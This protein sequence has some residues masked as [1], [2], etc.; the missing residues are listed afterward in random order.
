MY[1]GLRTSDILHKKTCRMEPEL[2]GP[3]YN[4]GLTNL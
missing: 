2:C 3:S 4:G 1:R